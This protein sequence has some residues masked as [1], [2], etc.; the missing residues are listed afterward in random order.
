[1][2]K[3]FPY[4]CG[5]IIDTLTVLRR[6]LLLTDTHPKNGMQLNGNSSLSPVNIEMCVKYKHVSLAND[7]FIY[8]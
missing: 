4:V 7:A 3:Y 1:M 8:I 6:A 5:I 2:L